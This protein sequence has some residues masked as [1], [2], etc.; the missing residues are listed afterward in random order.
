[1]WFDNRENEIGLVWVCISYI[2]KFLLFYRV[3]VG[4][5]K[6]KFFFFREVVS[7]VK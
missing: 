5:K 3:K 2:W 1:M 7:K 6:K 4:F